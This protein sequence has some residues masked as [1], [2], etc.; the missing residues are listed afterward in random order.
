[1]KLYAICSGLLAMAAV[2]GCVHDFGEANKDET[3]EMTYVLQ[4]S[5]AG[6]ER[7]LRVEVRLPMI[8]KNTKFFLPS[9]WAGEKEYWKGIRHLKAIGPGAA[10][11]DTADPAIKM[12]SA[13]D[14]TPISIEYELYETGQG[15]G[16]P[17]RPIL[18]TSFFHFIGESAFAYPE[19][20]KEKN[21]RIA[22]KWHGIPDGWTLANSFGVDQN[23]QIIT[24]TLRDFLHSIYVG[25][26][27]RISRFDVEN[28]PVYVAVR[29][30]WTFSDS[31]FSGHLKKVF[32]F[33]RAFWNDF[34]FPFFLVSLIPNGKP[35]CNYGGTGVS[36][37]FAT[38]VSDSVEL[39]ELR[40]L[41]THEL[42]HTWNGRKIERQD[43]E[44]LV[45]WFS[46]GFTD[47]YTRLLNLRAGIISLQEYVDDYNNKVARYYTSTVRN[48]PNERIRESFWNNDE[49]GKL[50]Y[51]RGDLLAHNWNLL[52]KRETKGKKSLDDFM[53]DVLN[54]AQTK[55]EVVSAAAINKLMI[56]YVPEG[57]L[58]DISRSID[59]GETIVPAANAL[60]PCVQLTQGMTGPFDMG[61]DYKTS[62][63]KGIIVGLKEGTNAFAAG[64]RNGQ[65]M[66]RWDVNRDDFWEDA[67]IKI[68][69][70]S[71]EKWIRF[72][73]ISKNATQVFRYVL[74]EKAYKKDTAKCTSWFGAA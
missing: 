3:V 17:Y 37:A 52:I 47:Y 53:R 69:T 40:H 14:N 22:L 57:V 35:C 13:P 64:L 11:S 42:L 39:K 8:E 66:V 6:S 51:Q 18:K 15:T 71:K 68:K 58:I 7:F 55:H 16:N 48:E 36:N 12:L 27:F 25:G 9:H 21:I 60:G 38:F 70:G 73:P 20:D 67:A 43:P 63:Q 41:Y 56:Q 23:E 5:M 4:P 50:P 34:D 59:R 46:E 62:R 74:D 1:M 2:W 44:E 33:E 28:R 65:S 72:R 26:D 19:Y 29:G 45:Y 32:S 54:A 49:V 24:A 31:E 61:F 30:K 10:I